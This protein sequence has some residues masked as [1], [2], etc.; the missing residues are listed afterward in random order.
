MPV[1][2][3]RKDLF[4]STMVVDATIIAHTCEF[5]QRSHDLSARMARRQGLPNGRLIPDQQPAPRR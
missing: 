5:S 2:S 3:A 4:L 1:I